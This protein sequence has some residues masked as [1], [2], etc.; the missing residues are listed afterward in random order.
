MKYSAFA[1]AAVAAA[2]M[3]SAQAKW[4]PLNSKEAKQA[5]G[6]AVETANLPAPSAIAVPAPAV[7]I[8]R[9]ETATGSPA[10]Q[11]QASPAPVT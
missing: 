7:P 6:R 8:N 9:G 5:Q 3:A 2:G 1:L 10:P 4:A 11:P